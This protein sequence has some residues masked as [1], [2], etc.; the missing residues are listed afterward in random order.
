MFG[1]LRTTLALMVMAFHLF[2]GIAPLGKYAVFGF[3]VISGYLM[4]LVMNDTYGHTWSGRYAFALNRLLRLY[5]QYWAA[6]TFSI[7]LILGGN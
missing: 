1:V 5:P 3:Y 7:V 2:A 4:T 6:A